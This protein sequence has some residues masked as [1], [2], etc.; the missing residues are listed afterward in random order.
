MQ[1][2]TSLLAAFQD[3]LVGSRERDPVVLAEIAAMLHTW[4][5]PFALNQTT[6]PYQRPVCRHLDAALDAALRGPESAITAAIIPAIAALRW[7]YGYPFQ[8][9][10][11]DLA[12]TIGFAQ[13]L[14]PAGLMD[15]AQLHIGLTLM[16]PATHY[17]MHSHPAIETYLV[18]S[19]TALW[20]ISD[21][22]FVTKSPG[23]LIVHTSSIGHAMETT[24]TPLLA[25]FVWRGDLVT[26][27]VYVDETPQTTGR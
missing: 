10:W 13:L 7:T 18:L 2:V 1:T 15:D 14:G 17:P 16:A 24:K 21:R 8:P 11:P 9:Q 5:Q 20:R 26:A 6:V 4:P 12:D 27:P 22:P 25:L 19:G 23:A 3:R